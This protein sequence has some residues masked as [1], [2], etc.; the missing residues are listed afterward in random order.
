[1]STFELFGKLLMAGYTVRLYDEKSD[2]YLSVSYEQN[3]TIIY[4]SDDVQSMMNRL[5]TVPYS[6][7]APSLSYLE[8]ALYL[9]KM[10]PDVDTIDCLVEG[11]TLNEL[12]SAL[13]NGI[14]IALLRATKRG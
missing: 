8:N 11:F 7:E 13:D 5:R 1:M 10:Y 2:W 12:M 9:H 14:D 4:H 3:N 6:Y